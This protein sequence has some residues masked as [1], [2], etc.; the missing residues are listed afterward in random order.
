M[1]LTEQQDDALSELLNIAFGRAAATLSE[2]AEQRVLLDTSSVALCET[3]AL[4]EAL[5]RLV[6]GQGATVHVDFAGPVSGDAFLVLDQ[7]DAS[8]LVDLLRSALGAPLDVSYQEALEEAGNILLNACLGTLG[9]L[10][11]ANVGFSAPH[12]YPGALALALDALKMGRSRYALV[13]STVIRLQELAVSGH[14]LIVMDATEMERLLQAA[15][16]LAEV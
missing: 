3:S 14:L 11:Q 7:D 13:A 2:L 15:N 6:A 4:E 12:F 1:I 5:S 16:G 10:L 8:L 9:N